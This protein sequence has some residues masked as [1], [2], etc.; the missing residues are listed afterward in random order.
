MMLAGGALANRYGGK[1]VLGL[2]V[3]WWSLCTMLTPPAALVSLPLLVVARIALGLGEAAVFPASINMIGRWVPPLQ[4]SRAVA[5]LA[6]MIN[7]GSVFALPVTGMLI[8]EYGWP[9]PFYAFGAAG[10]VWAMVWFAGVRGGNNIDASDSGP[11]PAIPWSR[12]LSRPAVWAIV[13]A[14]FGF[15]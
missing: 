14:Q 12:L 2:A 6:S 10:L 11:P 4:R 7:I 13:I 15:S 8:R 9:V 3:V 5:L 1:V